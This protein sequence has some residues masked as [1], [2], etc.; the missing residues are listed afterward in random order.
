MIQI[1]VFTYSTLYSYLILI[2]LN[3]LN[4]FWKNPKYQISRKSAQWEP[5]SMWTDKR[6]DMMRLIVTLRNFTNGPK[7]MP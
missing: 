1:L 5:S 6:T 2:N 4:R 3:F 7:T